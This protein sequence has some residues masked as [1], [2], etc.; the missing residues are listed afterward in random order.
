MPINVFDLCS[1]N[2]CLHNYIL[3]CL[4]E[5]I[6]LVNVNNCLYRQRKKKKK[7]SFCC[8]ALVLGTNN[9]QKELI[10]A[11]IKHHMNTSTKA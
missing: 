5:K 7:K 1:V 8:F 11:H 9:K 2:D 3:S 10:S 4:T 6:L